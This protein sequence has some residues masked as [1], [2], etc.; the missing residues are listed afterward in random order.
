MLSDK[1]LPALKEYIQNIKKYYEDD[2]FQDRPGVELPDYITRRHHLY[3]SSLQKS[4]KTALQRSGI[5]KNAII[6]TGCIITT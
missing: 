1:V 6:H 2:R 3:S 4:F 5:A